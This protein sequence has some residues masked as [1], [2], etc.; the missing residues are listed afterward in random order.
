MSDALAIEAKTAI[1][2]QSNDKSAKFPLIVNTQSELKANGSDPVTFPEIDRG[3]EI[4]RVNNVSIRLIGDSQISQINIDKA[5]EDDLCQIL[6]E[7]QEL[8]KLPD[9]QHATG[10][11]AMLEKS[12]NAKLNIQSNPPPLKAENDREVTKPASDQEYLV[13]DIAKGESLWAIARNFLR[14]ALK[15]EATNNEIGN[16]VENIKKDENNANVIFNNGELIRAGDQLHIAKSA[17]KGKEMSAP[18]RA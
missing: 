12:L 18:S 15:R 5:G 8:K 9:F 2:T 14:D 11:F 7:L 4:I 10:V 3:R 13:H 16:L 1:V 17:I 6:I